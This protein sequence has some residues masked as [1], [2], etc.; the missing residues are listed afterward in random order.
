MRSEKRVGS[1]ERVAMRAEGW[2]NGG[3]RLNMQAGGGGMQR[4][5][6]FGGTFN[7]IHVGHLTLAEEALIAGRL[8][9]VVLIPSGE[10][11]FKD[12]LG[13]ASREDRLRMTQLACRGLYDVSDI[14]IRREG[15]SYTSVTCDSFKRSHPEDALFLLL[16]ADSLM[17]IEKWHD[18]EAIF[19]C[20]S[21]LAFARGGEDTEALHGQAARLSKLYGAQIEVFDTFRLSLSSSEIRGRIAEGQAFRHLVTE[22]VYQYICRKRL[23]GFIS[24][25]D[26]TR[27]NAGGE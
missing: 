5:G 9:R 17:E 15:P 3:G 7:P 6:L 22:P 18:F 27:G 11:Y 20:S 25:Q 21:I 19:R 12:L 16:G 8:D 10:S 1:Q 13:I 24:G 4:I 26:D 23:Y 14:E 2:Y